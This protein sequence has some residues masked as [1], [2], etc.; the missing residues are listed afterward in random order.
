MNVPMPQVER[1]D[2]LAVPGCGSER[3][4]VDGRV[5]GC[6]LLWLTVACGVRLC[7][8]VCRCE[9]GCSLLFLESVVFSI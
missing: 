2:V 3:C 6:E 4:A 1:V 8:G 5:R 9:L 7:F